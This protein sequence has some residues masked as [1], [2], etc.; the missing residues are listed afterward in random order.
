MVTQFV[1]A[2]NCV[3]VSIQPGLITARCWRTAAF[4]DHPPSIS[5]HQVRFLVLFDQRGLSWFSFSRQ[6]FS[7]FCKQKD[8]VSLACWPFRASLLSGLLD[9]AAVNFFPDFWEHG[10]SNYP[11]VQLCRKGE[12]ISVIVGHMTRLICGLQKR[13]CSVGSGDWTSSLSEIPIFQSLFCGG[14]PNRN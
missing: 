6:G 1:A 10:I 9:A 4:L 5:R 11:T 12:P 13:L 7:S 8:T 3:R 14:Y 2:R